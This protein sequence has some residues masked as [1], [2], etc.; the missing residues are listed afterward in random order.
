[1]KGDDQGVGREGWGRRSRTHYD[2]GVPGDT[3]WGRGRDCCGLLFGGEIDIG[4]Q[5]FVAGGSGE[6]RT[7]RGGGGQGRSA[8]GGRKKARE[9]REV[10]RR[11]RSGSAGSEV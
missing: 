8:E 6:E 1:M 10:R 9:G 4:C 5:K 3:G 7:R 2:W 11:E